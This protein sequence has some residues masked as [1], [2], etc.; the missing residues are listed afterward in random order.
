M[1]SASETIARIAIIPFETPE[2]LAEL[3]R[4]N[5]HDVL[6]M[7]IRVF[8][9]LAALTTAIGLARHE[10]TLKQRIRSLDETL[11]ALRKIEQAVSILSESKN[12][13]EEEAYRRLRRKSQ[14][15]Q[16]NV[17]EIAEAIIASSDI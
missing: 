17:A 12:I 6:S 8:G 13:S 14:N 5:V 11:K 4:L 10:N 15:S 3:E 16:I 1:E 7:P 9:I 2:I